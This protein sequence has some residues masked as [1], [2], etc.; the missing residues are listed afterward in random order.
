MCL[1]MWQLSLFCSYFVFTNCMVQ[2][3]YWYSPTIFAEK[4]YNRCRGGSRTAV[5]FK[6]ELFVTVVNGWKP[7]TINTKNSILNVAAVLD[8]PLVLADYV[9]LI[10][11]I[12]NSYNIKW[13]IH[14][15]NLLI[16][17]PLAK[18]NIFR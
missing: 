5:T 11:K 10:F 15:S 3:E 8:L 7:L 6:M 12:L 4:S 9:M 17:Q 13:Y 2:L 16:W 18:K 1:C 14:L